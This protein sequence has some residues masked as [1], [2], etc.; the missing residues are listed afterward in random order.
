MNFA[1]LQTV[2]L[3]KVKNLPINIQRE[4]E[5]FT[6]HRAE[7]IDRFTGKLTGQ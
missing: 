2:K 1:Q 5:R 3:V 4:V 6:V 7:K